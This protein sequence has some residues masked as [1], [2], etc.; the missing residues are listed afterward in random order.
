MTHTGEEISAWRL[1]KTPCAVLCIQGEEV[2]CR[3]CLPRFSS[4]KCKGIWLSHY[5]P[6]FMVNYLTKDEIFQVGLVAFGLHATDHTSFFPLFLRSVMIHRLVHLL[7]VACD[8]LDVTHLCLCE[9]P[10]TFACMCNHTL[11]QIF[12]DK[13]HGGWVRGLVP[14]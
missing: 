1:H 2:L 13:W 3:L 7:L 8:R 10:S 12:C 9:L 4:W 5:K 6:E 11:N 14:F